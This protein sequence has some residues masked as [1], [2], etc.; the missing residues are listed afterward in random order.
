MSRFPYTFGWQ[1]ISLPSLPCSGFM[2]AAVAFGLQAVLSMRRSKERAPSVLHTPPPTSQ[3]LGSRV[4]E[5]GGQR[6]ERNQA[7]LHVNRR[8]ADP[9]AAV[10][11][12]PSISHPPAPSSGPAVSGYVLLILIP[13]TRPVFRP[14]VC[15]LAFLRRRDVAAVEQVATQRSGRRCARRGQNKACIPARPAALATG[16]HCLLLLSNS[17]CKSNDLNKSLNN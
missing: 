15:V 3:I 4:Y 1:L 16:T 5:T 14:D 12:L 9:N 8:A 6:W 10:A 7:R 13:M 2:A 17:S 11:P